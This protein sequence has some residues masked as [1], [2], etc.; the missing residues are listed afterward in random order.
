MNREVDSV[1]LSEKIRK[2]TN[3]LSDREILMHMFRKFYNIKDSE[4]IA[5]RTLRQYKENFKSFEAFLD[6]KI[7]MFRLE[8]LDLDFFREYQFYMR[9]EVVKFQNHKYNLNGNKGLA[10]ATIRTR[11]KTLRV[12]FNCM[13][14]EGYIDKS[15]I[16]GLKQYKEIDSDIKVLTKDELYRL[17]KSQDKLQYAQFRDHVLLNL[18]IDTMARIGEVTRLTVDDF[19]FDDLSVYIPANISKS[20]RA[21]KL[22]LHKNTVDLLKELIKENQDFNSEYLFLTGYGNVYK[23][24]AFNKRLKMYAEKAGIS[25]RLHSHLLRHTGATL[26]LENGGDQRHLQLLLG[27]ADFRMI[28]RYTHLGDKSIRNQHSKHSAINDVIPKLKRKRKNK[29]KYWD[30]EDL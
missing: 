16:R 14:F 6:E 21:R 15:P 26:F 1:E 10:A 9:N 8:M 27:H 28:L 4:G 25:K 18:L 22:P 3:G 12:F 29:R 7:M 24:D 19:N 11:I 23:K 20:G 2:R 5:S 30:G 13:E 17:L